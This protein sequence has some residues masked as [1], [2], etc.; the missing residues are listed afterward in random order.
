MIAQSIKIA[1]FS[2]EQYDFLYNSNAPL[3]IADG[4]VRSGK[5]F[6]ENVRL[7]KY[8]YDEPAS[9]PLSPFIF[10][11]VNKESVY[12][13]VF[14]DLF[15]LIG[16]GNYKYSIGKGKGTVRSKYGWREFYAVADKDADDFKG[17]RGDTVGGF[18]INEGT[19][20]HKE[21]FIELLARK[22]SIEDS[23][24]FVDTNSDTPAHWLYTEYM[25]DEI[26]LKKGF[27]KR[28]EFNIF[29]NR[30]LTE[31]AIE[32]IKALYKPG[33]L[34][35][36]RKIENKWVLADGAIYD[37]FDENRH[38]CEPENLPVK[39]DYYAIAGDFGTN[40]P[41]VFLLIGVF[42]NIVY[43][44]DEYY[45]SGRKSGKQKTADEYVID[46]QNFINS[47]IPEEKR[48]KL[49]GLYFDPSATPLFAAIR[50]VYSLSCLL[51]VVDNSVL[52]GISTVNQLYYQNRLI[53][54]KMC[55][56]TLKEINSY[57]WDLQASIKQ[58]KDIPKKE[59]DHCMDAKRYFCHTK[60]SNEINMFPD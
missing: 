42:R 58:G 30:S 48:N 38:T 15:K 56:E 37:S 60:F 24:G 36:K 52:D 10:A 1:P 2:R 18:S 44:I 34:N 8:L 26:L 40:N 21:T 53:I 16:E 47:R 45:Y 4:P 20:C 50:K 13:N 7:K 19:L 59:W 54:C 49:E 11:G 28:F 33:T 17:I 35:Y 14:R 31:K 43:I 39:F 29:S 23:C 6:I 55:K 41:C 27:V 22:S 46:L 51:K 3:N 9:A 12:K 57:I 25:T 5:N 32:I